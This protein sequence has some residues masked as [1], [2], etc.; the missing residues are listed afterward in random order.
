[1]EPLLPGFD[2]SWFLDLDVTRCPEIWP[3]DE[4]LTGPQPDN[5]LHDEILG[6]SPP[7]DPEF[8]RNLPDQDQQP[9]S[10]GSYA[11]GE[12]FT[13]N[14]WEIDSMFP[15]EINLLKPSDG[16][17]FDCFATDLISPEQLAVE[18][19]SRERAGELFP[20]SQKISSLHGASRQ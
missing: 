7:R 14:S 6:P 18:S 4:I 13:H 10:D 19:R 15:L 8:W 1:M 9:V 5:D 16:K 2:D 17:V 3:Q 12:L 11:P 20:P